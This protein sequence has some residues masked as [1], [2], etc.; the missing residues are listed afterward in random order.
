MNV[1]AIGLSTLLACS[2]GWA[3]NAQPGPAAAG[4]MY[5]Q[6]RPG[7]LTPGS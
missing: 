1:R 2:A 5:A 4:T 3:A 6:E 7:Y